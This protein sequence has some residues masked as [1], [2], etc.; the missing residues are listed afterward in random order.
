MI[1]KPF[2]FFR[3]E[4]RTEG[5]REG[6]RAGILDVYQLSVA[7]DEKRNNVCKRSETDYKAGEII[8]I[9]SRKKNILVF[10][11]FFQYIFL[12]LILIIIS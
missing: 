8:N 2:Y 1:L 10:I 12:Y 5:T 3:V 7:Y 6:G 9:K 11:L 4:C